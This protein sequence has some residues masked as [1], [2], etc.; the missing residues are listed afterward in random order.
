[1]K[2]NQILGDTRTPSH[3]PMLL[4]PLY[5]SAIS[6]TTENYLAKVDMIQILSNHFLKLS[7]N[8]FF[9]LLIISHMHLIPTLFH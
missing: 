7:L 5:N 9:I 4:Y 2:P 6:K 8:I 3:S 1:M